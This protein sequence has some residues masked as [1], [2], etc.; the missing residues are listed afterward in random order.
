MFENF[1]HTDVACMCRGKN[2]HDYLQ[3]KEKP[4]YPVPALLIEFDYWPAE[5]AWWSGR[6]CVYGFDY[7][8]PNRWREFL[9]VKA[10]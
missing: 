7:Y 3:G 5:D 6:A 8:K 4:N 1:Y 10:E 2:L 9:N